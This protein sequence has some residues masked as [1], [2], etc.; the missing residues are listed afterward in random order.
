MAVCESAGGE[1]L[2]EV[3]GQTGNSKSSEIKRFFGKIVGAREQSSFNRKQPG[4]P[5]YLELRKF[6]Y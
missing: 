6:Q 2:A 5:N 3:R 4:F 1:K